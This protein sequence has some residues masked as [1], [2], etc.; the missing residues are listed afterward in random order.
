MAVQVV[1]SVSKADGMDEA[2]V[3]LTIIPEKRTTA[4]T[5]KLQPFTSRSSLLR[6][7][8]VS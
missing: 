7:E 3:Y 8:E 6:A 5:E 2:L 4:V 1:L